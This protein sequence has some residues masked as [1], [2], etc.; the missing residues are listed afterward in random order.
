MTARAM[1]GDRERCLE[2]GMDDYVS[3]PVRKEEL[4]RALSGLRPPSAD[5]R[6]SM[7]TQRF[8][9]WIGRSHSTCLAATETCC[10]MLL[11]PC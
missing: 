2:A 11:T 7:S 1:K 3:K 4:Y 6:R 5:I 8:Q 10:V 9:W